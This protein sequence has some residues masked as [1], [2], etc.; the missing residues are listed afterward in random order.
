[1]IMLFFRKDGVGRVRSKGTGKRRVKVKDKT[2]YVLAM[3]CKSIEETNEDLEFEDLFGEG[4]LE[5]N[6]AG[7]GPEL[8]E[9]QCEALERE[10]DSRDEEALNPERR[11]PR[12]RN[13]ENLDR[14]RWCQTK[15]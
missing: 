14:A 9:E 13:G 8:D 3:Q 7:L 6:G 2:A 10:G 15:R 1:M 12:S 5:D 11:K 4:S